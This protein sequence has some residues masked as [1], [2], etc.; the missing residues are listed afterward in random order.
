[1]PGRGADA[2]V[3]E[4]EPAEA[5][6]GWALVTGKTRPSQQLVDVSGHCIETGGESWTGIYVE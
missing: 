2:V 1:M 3:A 5:D 4:D 6:E